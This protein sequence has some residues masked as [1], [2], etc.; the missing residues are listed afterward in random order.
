MVNWVEN[1]VNSYVCLQKMCLEA[2]PSHLAYIIKFVVANQTVCSHSI[3]VRI[4]DNSLA[5]NRKLTQKIW[6]TGL[7]CLSPGIRK[8]CD[9]D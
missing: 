9:S 4:S 7:N 2:V 8:K 3:P 1:I 5:E 6:E